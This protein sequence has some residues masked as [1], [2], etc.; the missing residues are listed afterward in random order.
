MMKQF[1][2]I[3]KT[4]LDYLLFYH[5]GDFYELFFDDAVKAA[6]ALDIALTKRGTHAGEDIPMCGVPHHSSEQYLQKLIKKGFKVAVCEQMENPAEAK[7]RGAKSVVRREVTRIITPGTLTEDSL[8]EASNSNYLAALSK[9][10]GEIAIAWADISTGSFEVTHVSDEN[11]VASE[12]SRLSP[13]ELLLADSWFDNRAFIGKIEDWRSIL[14]PHVNSIFDSSRAERQLKEFFKLDTIAAFDL[15]SRAEVSACG[16]LLEYVELTQKENLP[17]LKYPHH[18]STSQHMQLDG[19]TRKNLELGATL[20]GDFQGSLLSVIDRTVSNSGARLLRKQLAAPLLDKCAINNRLDMVEYFIKNQETRHQIKRELSRIPD[21]ERALSRIYIGRAGPRDLLVIRAGLY[22]ASNILGI[23]ESADKKQLPDSLASIITQIDPKDSLI[24]LLSEALRDETPILARDGGF[25]R[26]GYNPSL[27]EF[28]NAQSRSKELKEE[29]CDVYKNLT[30]VDRLK[31]GDNNLIGLYIEVSTQHI[32]K[33]PDEFVHRQTLA[34]AVRYSTPE[35]K[36]LENKIINAEHS[37]LLLELEIFDKL[38]AEVIG[39]SEALSLIAQALSSLDVASSLAEIAEE[40]DYCRPNLENSTELEIKNARHPVVERFLHDDFIQNDCELHDGQ[41][42]LLLTGPNMAGKSTYLRQN[43][44]IIIMAQMGAFVP[45]EI[46]N[47]GIVDRV[48]SRVGAADD[49]ARGQSTFMV[50]MVETATILN[51]AT[52]SSFV[53]L[54]E[55]GRGTATYDGLSIA[56]AVVEY[57]HNIS[58]CRS[59]FATHY[60]ELTSLPDKLDDMSCFTVQVKEWEDKIIFL[61]KVI[62]GTADRSYGIHVGKLAGLP[63]EVTDR[64]DEV[65]KLI[66]NKDG[67]DTSQ[68]LAEELPL[69]ASSP[70][71]PTKPSAVEEMLGEINPDSLTPR[72]ALDALYKLKGQN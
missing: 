11:A 13:K 50:E 17:R 62:A 40:R 22:G 37:A 43:A 66:Q 29:L 19:A 20:N 49:L 68:K 16:A 59:L 1:I 41:K 35:L 2:S 3:K 15:K 38:I 10:Q 28:R 26:D 53:I 21:I 8:L 46:A 24:D 42:L 44:I 52:K 60:H 7:K 12:L 67:K 65:L 4:H 54:D 48:F 33:M 18:F 70:T 23:F 9:V 71:A 72:E 30:G 63:K 61:H 36:E 31:I 47:I 32:D 5:M 14:T 55:I 56:W 69:F 34:N 6:R 58:K 57:L 27:D 51:N 45:A 25:V 64:A 39:Q